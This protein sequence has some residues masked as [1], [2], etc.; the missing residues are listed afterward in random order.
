MRLSALTDLFA[1]DGGLA[2]ATDATHATGATGATGAAGATRPD[3]R[4]GRARARHRRPRLM[5]RE[6]LT[7]GR[8]AISSASHAA[9]AAGASPLPPSR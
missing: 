2:D 7:G 3:A 9:P 8:V 5:R 1:A 4:A 6:S